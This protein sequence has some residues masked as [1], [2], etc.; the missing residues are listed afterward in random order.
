ME[1][2]REDDK[3]FVML[4]GILAVFRFSSSSSV[5]EL[6]HADGVDPQRASGGNRV[7]RVHQRGVVGGG[8]AQSDREAGAETN[9]NPRALGHA[10]REAKCFKSVRMLA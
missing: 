10:G 9:E 4:I 2:K 5:L 7:N 1:E 3:Q 6:T 8:D